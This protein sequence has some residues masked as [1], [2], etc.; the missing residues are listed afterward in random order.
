MAVNVKMGVD[1]SS[2]NSG[3]REGQGILKG[4]NAEMKATEAEFKATG[5]AEKALADK[6]KTLNSQLQVQKGIADQ[7]AQAL[8]AMEEAGIKP[9]DQAYQKLYAT[10]MNAQAGMNEA[11]AALNSLSSGEKQAAQEANNLA[12]GV[13]SIGKKMSLEQVIGGIDRITGAMENAAKKAIQFG[14]EIWKNI[15]DSAQLSDDILTQAGMLDMTP[16]MYQR[17]KGVFDTIGEITITEWA[18]AKRK[19]EKVMTDP[20]N[21]QIDVLRALGFVRDVSTPYGSSEVTDLADNWE[22]VFWDAAT[23]LKSKVESGELTSEMADVYGEALFGKKYSSLKNLINLGQEAFTAALGE[24]NV[25]SDEALEKN[26]ALNDAVIKLQNSFDA[27]KQEVTSALAPAL[28]DAATALDGVLGKILEYLQKPE[29][30]EMLQKLGDAI[31]GLFGDLSKIDPEKVVEGF[32]EVFTKVT[33]G[34]EWLV[35]NAETAKGILAAIVGAWGTITIGEN[36]MKVYKLVDG[37]AGLSAADAAAAGTSAGSSWAGAFATAAMKAAPFLVFL[38]ELLNPGSTANDQIDTMF[39]KET[40]QLTEEGKEAGLTEQDVIDIINTQNAIKDARTWTRES[41]GL[42]EKQLNALESF[43]NY[44]MQVRGNPNA[45][46]V[47]KGQYESYWKLL[48]GGLFEGQEQQLTA[49]LTKMGEYFTA[50]GRGTLDLSFF[51]I[52]KD[53]KPVEIP[54]EL[55]VKTSAE[56]VAAQIGTVPINAVLNLSGFVAGGISGILAGLPHFANGTPFV[57][58]DNTLALLHK[59]ERVL[60]A[61]QNRHYTYNSNNYFGNVNLNNGQDIEALCNSIDRHNRR[62]RSG[63]GS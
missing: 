36:V 31:S 49:Y 54:V 60:T 19:V 13:Q 28:T 6:T 39:D 27:L 7:A 35:D 21:D 52:G 55:V 44:Y 38:Y 10:M 63:Y 33:G 61:N 14:E 41:T 3:I 5:N 4:L 51:N 30:Q 8:K 53:G 18:A 58:A 17:Y 45:S 1:L 26:A 42:T 59:G 56:A 46:D 40:N 15:M 48:N 29:G 47:I 16:E 11:Q 23:K 22:Q 2:F 32:V 12:Q 9:T 25:T 50:G 57:Q 34:I 43:W 62:Q 20:S 24:Q 37:I